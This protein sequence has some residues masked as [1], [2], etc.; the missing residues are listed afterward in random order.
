[1]ARVTRP[2][3]VVAAAVWDYG[4]GMGMLRTFW[5]AAPASTPGRRARRGDTMPLGRPGGLAATC[6]SATGLDRRR[7]GGLTMAM[8]FIVFDDYWEPFL[9]GAGPGRRPRRPACR[10]PV[11]RPCATELAGPP[12]A[13]PFEL[14]ATA[15]WVRGTVPA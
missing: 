12:G 5:D 13:G 3:G 4:G 9:L 14:T 2:G 11:A 6:G 1:M 7:R 15:W 10:M 8:A